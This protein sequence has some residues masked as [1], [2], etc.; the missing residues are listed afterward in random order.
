MDTLVHCELDVGLCQSVRASSLVF[1]IQWTISELR[2]RFY[3]ENN[4]SKESELLE[5][6]ERFSI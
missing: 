6:C 4:I 2:E 3:N 5:K 1:Q